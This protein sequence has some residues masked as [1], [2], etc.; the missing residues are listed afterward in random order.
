MHI[1]NNYYIYYMCVHV[2]TYTYKLITM[3]TLI[4]I[5]PKKMVGLIHITLVSLFILK[6]LFD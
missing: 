4:G 1:I 6:E 2:Y 5:F 3:C